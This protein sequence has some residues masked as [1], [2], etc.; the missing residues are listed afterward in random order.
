M[1]LQ[2]GF[3]LKCEGSGIK[4]LQST[5]SFAIFSFP[6]LVTF[7]LLCWGCGQSKHVPEALHSVDGLDGSQWEQVSKPGFGDDANTAIVAMA[8]YCGRLYALV[9]NDDEGVEVW[10]T[11]GT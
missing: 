4:L 6:V 3:N 9:R 10:R 11:S 5:F 2:G 1:I 8:E 7:F